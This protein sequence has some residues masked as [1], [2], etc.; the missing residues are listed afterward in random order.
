MA[1]STSEL[2]IR[3]YQPGD[4]YGILDCFNRTFAEIDVGF[5]PRSMEFWRW[6]YEQNPGGQRIFVA[7]DEEGVVHSHY[8]GIPVRMWLERGEV[9]FDQ[10]VDS[11]T[12]R[13]DRQG[14]AKRFSLFVKTALPFFDT[15]GGEGRDVVMYGLP[16]PA[17]WRIGR[18]FMGYQVVRENTWLDRTLGSNPSWPPMP[19]DF[20]IEECRDVG[21]WAGEV[22]T[23]FREEHRCTTL[24]DDAFLNWRYRSKPGVEYTFVVARRKGHPEPLG[25]L[26]HRTGDLIETNLSLLCDWVVPEREKLAALALLAWLDARGRADSSQRIRALLPTTSPWFLFL[27]DHGYRVRPSTYIMVGRNYVKPYPM[28]WLREHWYYTLGD[29]DLA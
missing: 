17:A 16:V 7:I 22:W 10:I 27:Q 5:V 20:E 12:R 4:E 18:A 21:P 25:Y 28:I 15:Y 1:A 13:D 11:M 3:P 9:L 2:T 26:V 29:T 6:Q 19:R 14:L 24:R 23:R 8:G